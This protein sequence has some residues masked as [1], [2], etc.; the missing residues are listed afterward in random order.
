MLTT[1]L[2]LVLLLR[3][4]SSVVAIDSAIFQRPNTNIGNAWLQGAEPQHYRQ[5]Y[6]VSMLST[7]NKLKGYHTSGWIGGSIPCN[8]PDSIYYYLGPLDTCFYYYNNGTFSSY[9][10][11][12]EI[13]G[14]IIINTVTVYNQTNDCQEIPGNYETTQF[15]TASCASNESDA[16]SMFQNTIFNSNVPSDDFYGILLGGYYADSS[17]D[18][19]VTGYYYPG[20]VCTYAGTFSFVYFIN[21]T[22]SVPSLYYKVFHDTNCLHLKTST[23]IQKGDS[24]CEA[25]SDD[26]DDYYYGAFYVDGYSQ[27]VKFINSGGG[28]DSSALSTAAAAAIGVS[29]GFVGIF[30]IIGLLVWNKVLSIPA[31][32]YGNKPL[33]DST[34]QNDVL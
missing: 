25:N 3:L 28:G 7:H 5:K 6:R 4:T 11:K 15:N 27:K 10:I 30:A 21:Y 8:S 16:S 24:D 34:F 26:Y 23:F 22:D 33:A 9:I 31:C 1:L 2:S 17:C 12:A 14:D 20:N 29:V 19:I 13:S 32:L 18:D